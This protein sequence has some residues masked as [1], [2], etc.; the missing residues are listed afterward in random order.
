MYRHGRPDV[1]CVVSSEFLFLPPP[2]FAAPTVFL[3]HPRPFFPRFFL[4][5]FRSPITYL[6]S[7]GA[8]LPLAAPRLHAF[9]TINDPEAPSSARDRRISRFGFRAR[10]KKRGG[11]YARPRLGALRN[12]RTK[13]GEKKGGD[14]RETKGRIDRIRSEFS[15]KFICSRGSPTWTKTNFPTLPFLS[16]LHRSSL[17]FIG[18]RVRRQ[19]LSFQPPLRDCG[20]GQ[21]IPGDDFETRS[22]PLPL[23]RDRASVSKVI[24]RNDK[25]NYAPT[26]PRVNISN[27]STQYFS[28]SGGIRSHRGLNAKKR[29]NFETLLRDFFLMQEVER[30]MLDD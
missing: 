1:V 20:F 16:P 28:Y 19:S 2:F 7:S 6:R 24:K 22:T 15:K 23:L 5:L 30:L 4:S 12:E 13:A 17:T 9:D 25:C 18:S 11:A 10:K 26:V 21:V 14:G 29:N 3:S 27:F 8:Q